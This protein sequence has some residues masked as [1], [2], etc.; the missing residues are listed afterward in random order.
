MNKI[1]KIFLIVITLFVLTSINIAQQ[2][3]AEQLYQQA[4]Y[5]ME[6][7]G[8]YSKA[9][10]SF[11]LV[12][13]KFP[14]EK[15]IAAKALLN[16]GRCYEKLGK[17]E[18]QKAYERIIIEFKDQLQI[19]AEARTRLALLKQPADAIQSNRSNRQILTGAIKFQDISAPSPDGR[20]LSYSDNNK[21][22]LGIYDIKTGESK[23]IS[24]HNSSHDN[25]YV[26]ESI[27]SMDGK[28]LAYEFNDWFYHSEIHLVN[29]DG[30]GHRVLCTK[31]DTTA[32]YINFYV[33]DWS[34]DGKLILA[35]YSHGSKSNVDTEQVDTSE[36]IVI[37]IEDG[38]IRVIKVLDGWD[39]GITGKMFFSPDNRFIAFSY[40]NENKSKVCDVF[41][42]GVD[43]SNEMNITQHP[44]DD[45]VLGWE[46]NGNR[47]LFESDRGGNNNLWT[48]KIINGKPQG[49]PKLIQNNIAKVSS[50]GMT[51]DGSLY[52]YLSD[53]EFSRTDFFTESNIYLADIDPQSGKILS[54]PKAA[55]M[56]NNGFNHSQSWSPDGKQ[57]LYF[58]FFGKTNNSR[59][60]IFILSPES[61]SEKEVKHQLNG[62]S[63]LG[64]STWFPDGKYLATSVGRMPNKEN[65]IYKLE[66]ETGIMIPLVTNKDTSY[67]APKISPDGNILFF[68][69]NFKGIYSYDLKRKERKLLFQ[70]GKDQYLRNSVMSYDGGYL[71]FALVTYKPKYSIDM[72]IMPSTGGEP[73][74]IFKTDVVEL[75]SGSGSPRWSPDGKYIYFA[76]KSERESKYELCRISVQSGILE[77]TGF[78]FQGL[79][80]FF[81][82]PDGKEIAFCAAA[83]PERNIW[84]M[85]NVF[86]EDPTQ[87]TKLSGLTTRRILEDAKKIGDVLT[88]DGKYIRSVEGNTGNVKQFEIAT[89][90][91]TKII[92][93]SEWRENDKNN[94]ERFIFSHDGEK[95][96]YSIAVFDS[97][98]KKWG[99]EL[100]IRNLD[101]TD[102]RT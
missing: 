44:S 99:Y 36:L 64:G 40:P 71:A 41:V 30:T 37:S 86:A 96:V 66:I 2:N 26:G 47:L 5:E 19:V 9:I 98:T 57:L 65:G 31:T 82:R 59:R 94:T 42:I 4:L 54:Q 62:D 25:I 7:K 12:M 52:Y 21:N 63:L 102:L 92:N 83:Q 93:K 88:D 3:K 6:G 1:D 35:T 15:V 46:P 32:T 73:K 69:S 87:P 91:T 48:T 85:E 81:F 29:V 84:I 76:K 17:S 27:W 16:I 45:R 24:D 56:N 75:I 33:K 14:K 10:E 43:G 39:W 101:G 80:D 100:R 11:T 50:I 89:G 18:A 78:V 61:G 60:K 70:M 90:D 79:H 53:T 58:S 51:N 20:F 67:W 28:Q 74:S 77:S 55:T 97:V 72:M 49:F 23:I 95:I 68:D 34:H 13:T 8:D 38:S 22:V